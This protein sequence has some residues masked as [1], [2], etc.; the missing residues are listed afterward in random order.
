MNAQGALAQR[1]VPLPEPCR[2]CKRLPADP[3][4]AVDG[5]LRQPAAHRDPPPRLRRARLLAVLQA[6]VEWQAHVLAWGEAPTRALQGRE[7][8]V[9]LRAGDPARELTLCRRGVRWAWSRD[10][11]MDVYVEPSRAEPDGAGAVRRRLMGRG[12]SAAGSAG[13]K[14]ARPSGRDD[15]SKGVVVRFRERV[16]AIGHPLCLLKQ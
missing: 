2:T 15:R 4:S 3:F 12:D 16:F 11:G 8:Q 6:A 5:H 14:P 1:S 9:L 13:S 7:W 10:V